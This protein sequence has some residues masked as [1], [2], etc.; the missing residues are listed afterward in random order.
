M[1]KKSSTRAFTLIELLVVI[2]IIGLLA[3]IILA[4]L[5][6]ATGRARDGVRL[7]TLVSFR[8]AI[9]LYAGAHNG[10][11]PAGNYFSDQVNTG[12]PRDWSP[13]T[14]SSPP[15][16]AYMLSPYM[17][18]NNDPSGPNSG[19][20]SWSG[21]TCLTYITAK[22]HYY[23]YTDSFQSGAL[24]GSMTY[25]D[26]QVAAGTCYHKAIIVIVQPESRITDRQDCQFQDN[27][28]HGV[29]LKTLYP[30]AIIMLLN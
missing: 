21:S 27:V 13:I 16:L 2:S 17:T 9:N 15:S 25:P 14:E 26:D 28:A 24:L 12:N 5:N 18:L 10:A 23:F 8:N 11:F 30:N 4:G 3:S 22:H 7:Q 19:C 6:S 20:I 1:H 29:L